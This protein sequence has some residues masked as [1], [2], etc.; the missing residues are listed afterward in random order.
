MVSSLKINC[1]HKFFRP[2]NTHHIKAPVTWNR[3]A[4]E[5]E[6]EQDF[7]CNYHSYHCC[8]L[9]LQI[10]SA[11]SVVAKDKGEHFTM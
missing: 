1:N 9:Q 10:I 4:H 3:F 2:K 5:I 6:Q 11:S 8:Q 7:K